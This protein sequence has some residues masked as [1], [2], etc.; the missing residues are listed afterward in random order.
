MSNPLQGEHAGRPFGGLRVLDFTSMMAGPYCSRWLADLGAE[1][2]KI[3]PP[4]GDYMRSR[5]PLRAGDS[6]YF[7]HLNAGKKSVTLDLKSP[8]AVG[9]VQDMVR[10]SDILV[11]NFRPGVMDRLGLDYSRLRPLNPRLIYCSISGFGQTGEAASRPAF[12]QIVH[13]ASGFDLTNMEY[14]DGQERPAN[15]GIFVADVLAAV[16][17]GF[18]IS[19]ALVHRQKSGVGQHIDLTLAESMFS[20]LVFELQKAQF[21]ASRRRPMYKPSRARDGFVIIAAVSNYNFDNLFVAIGRPEWKDDPRFCSSAARL[22]NWD[23]LFALIEEWTMTRTAEDCERFLNQSG[24]P[25]SRYRTVSEAIGDLDALNRN[26]LPFVHDAAGAFRVTSLPFRFSA[27]DIS[28][29]S[30]VPP[31]GADTG[32]VLETVLGLSESEIARLAGDGAFG[33]S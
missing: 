7:G 24:V 33:R 26:S 6:S 31:L 3:E 5:P 21:P 1:V 8:A 27:A 17:G 23:E 25:C 29:G 13:A 19:A 30:T 4:E 15:T 16:Y 14:Q 9:L 32:G 20:L 2:I 11:E 28:V 12:A 10:N 18:A 22:E